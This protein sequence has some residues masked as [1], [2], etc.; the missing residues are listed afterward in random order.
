MNCFSFRNPCLSN[1]KSQ[2][3]QAIQLKM[4]FFLLAL[5]NDQP[6]NSKLA[7]TAKLCVKIF[8]ETIRQSQDLES[9]QKACYELGDFYL[10]FYN[11]Y[12]H[13]E[14]NIARFIPE[15]P[16]FANSSDD[17]GSLIHIAF[18]AKQCLEMV[19]NPSND[20][21]KLRQTAAA[22]Y[23]K[24]INERRREND[25]EAG[26]YSREFQMN[27]DIANLYLH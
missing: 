27:P 8:I 26:N 10:R 12:Q 24:A 6:S 7:E 16:L 14:T 21:A 17:R 20:I 2:C 25:A 23:E 3:E 22:V 9:Q 5:S 1:P 11:Q 18:S 19:Q 4:K 15:I 13:C